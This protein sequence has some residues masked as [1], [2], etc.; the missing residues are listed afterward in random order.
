MNDEW[1]EVRL[2]F[3]RGLR[4]LLHA[5]A[6]SQPA[7]RKLAEKASAKDL[8]ESCG[9]PHTE[10][11]LILLDGSSVGFAHHI[12]RNCNLEMFGCREKPVRFA[13]Q[14]L[15]TQ[16]A[17]Q[18]VTDGHL[19]KL[20]RRLR[21]LGFDV[22]YRPQVDDSELLRTMRDEGRALLTRD[23]RL[24]MHRIVEI[25]YCPRSDNAETQT[26][27]ITR[28]FHLLPCLLAP[29]TRC[30]RCNGRLEPVSKSEIE[31]RLEPLTKRYYESFKRCTDCD[32]I[33]WSGSHVEKLEHLIERVTSRASSPL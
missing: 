8:I 2:S 28:R 13:A 26:V 16:T 11:D 3:A 18:F 30:L 27:E 32:K 22:A 4:S 20:A 12:D 6:R 5:R 24:L 17:D 31:W 15:Q 25:G 10:I 1:F 21:L 7:L 19:G 33:Y 23:R 14:G 9:V 29:F